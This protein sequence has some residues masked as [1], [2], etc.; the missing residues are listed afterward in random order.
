MKKHVFYKLGIFISYN[1]HFSTFLLFNWRWAIFS[2]ILIRTACHFGWIIHKTVLQK[3]EKISKSARCFYVLRNERV[4]HLWHI[5][6]CSIIVHYV[7]SCSTSA[8]AAQPTSALSVATDMRELDE[9]S[10]IEWARLF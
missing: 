7:Y 10:S 3:T 2:I 1:T 6:T 8:A 4:N 9:F 5:V